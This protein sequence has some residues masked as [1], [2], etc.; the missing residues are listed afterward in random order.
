VT[1]RQ[2]INFNDTSIDVIE[3]WRKAQD[4]IPSFNEAVNIMITR[5]GAILLLEKLKT[6][7]E[8]KE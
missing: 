3:S 6:K 8:A 5:Y 1:K 2:S 7:L 4:K